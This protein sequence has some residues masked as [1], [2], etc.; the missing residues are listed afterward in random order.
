LS[1]VGKIQQWFA[2]TWK[3]ISDGAAAAWNWI[4]NIWNIVAPWFKTNVIDPLVAGFQI[5]WNWL[6]TTWGAAG[7]WFQDNFIGPIGQKFG[8]L[9]NAIIGY[10]M[11]LYERAIKPMA[12]WFMDYLWPIIQNVIGY[13]VDNFKKGFELVIVNLGIAWNFIVSIFQNIFIAIKD[14]V[15]GIIDVFQGVIK[16][17]TGLFT[18]DWKLA[19]E[20]IKDIIKGVFEGIYGVVKLI[21]NNIIDLINGVVQGMTTGLN[22]M[23]AGLNTIK[24]DIP[25]VVQKLLGISGGK[26]GINLGLLATPAK[27]PHLATGAVIPANA[28]FAAVLGD[29]RH[30]QNIEAPEELI[31][32]LI[33]EETGSQSPQKITIDFGNSSMGALIR[34]LNP[35]IKLDNDRLGPSLGTWNPS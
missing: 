4:L 13:L 35:I 16:Y 15:I 31:R 19:W 6:V 14:V 10:A 17:L 24:L 33:R 12:G 28:P 32:R 26:W 27:I 1:T 34:T 30:G 22:A 21:L 2:D 20:G 8:E 7:Q 3:V 5:A 29:Q 23:I 9:V 25:E 11:A 18:G